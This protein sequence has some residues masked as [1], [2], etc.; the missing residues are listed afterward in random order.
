MRFRK[1]VRP[2]SK[3]D[4]RQYATIPF[5][6]PAKPGEVIVVYGNGFG[7]TSTPVVAGS[8]TQGGTLSPP[9]V[10]KIG[11][12]TATV[13]Y[14]GLVGPGQFQFNVVVPPNTPDGDQ[15]ISATYAGGTTQTGTLLT[16]Q[17]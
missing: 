13:Q 8:Q 11:G 2:Y 9:P 7:T 6:S 1:D 4:G 17:H 12:N 10:F 15:T 3:D 16:V 5:L 14:A